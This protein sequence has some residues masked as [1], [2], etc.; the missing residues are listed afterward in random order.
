AMAPAVARDVGSVVLERLVRELNGIECVDFKLEPD[1]L[2]NTAVTRQFGEP[3]K[4]L[5]ELREAMA[6]RAARAAEKKRAQGLV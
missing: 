1:P 4:T 2:K 5:D 6:R 3:V